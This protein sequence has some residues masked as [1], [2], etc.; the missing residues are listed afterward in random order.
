MEDRITHV[1]SV[2]YMTSFFINNFSLF[3]HY[4]VIFKK[5]FTSLVPHYQAYMLS[6]L[7]TTALMIF[8]RPSNLYSRKKL[9]KHEANIL[10]Q[11]N[12]GLMLFDYPTISL[13]VSSF[14]YSSSS[15]S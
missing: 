14:S 4:L 3:V 11:W 15:N 1:V 7:I 10:T 2:Q 6:P 12:V 13:S 5:M 8:A 9:H